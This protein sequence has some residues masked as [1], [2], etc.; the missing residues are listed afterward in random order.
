VTPDVIVT[1]NFARY[2]AN[3]PAQ[4]QLPGPMVIKEALKEASEI[5]RELALI[6]R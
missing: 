6:P 4:R 3:H 5:S 2:L 1:E